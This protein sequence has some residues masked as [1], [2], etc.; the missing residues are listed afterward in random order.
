MR[1]VMQLVDVLLQCD[2]VDMCPDLSVKD[3]VIGKQANLGY[4]DAVGNVVDI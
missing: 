1:P 3:T 2:T 4:R